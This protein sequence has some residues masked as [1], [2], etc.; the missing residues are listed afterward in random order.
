MDLTLRWNLL[1]WWSRRTRLT[2]DRAVAR[3]AGRLAVALINPL[4]LMNVFFVAL[5]SELDVS[6]ALLVS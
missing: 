4:V 5:Q 1:W 6:I 2:V 3:C